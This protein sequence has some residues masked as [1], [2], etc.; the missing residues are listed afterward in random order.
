[1]S[2]ELFEIP[3][4]LYWNLRENWNCLITGSFHSTMIQD[5]RD[6]IK[7]LL[8]PSEL[9]DIQLIPTEHLWGE[10][11]RRN[12]RTLG[13]CICHVYVFICIYHATSGNRIVITLVWVMNSR[14][15]DADNIQVKLPRQTNDNEIN[16]LCVKECVYFK[17][18][19]SVYCWISFDYFWMAEICITACLS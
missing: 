5:T 6:K 15:R 10:L 13:Y 2:L 1:M 17:G 18:V 12:C 7:C 16:Y 19:K 9:P 11:K 14:R 3:G 8:W 4:N